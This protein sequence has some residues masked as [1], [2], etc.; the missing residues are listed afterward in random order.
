MFFLSNLS[1]YGR[2]KDKRPRKKRNMVIG[3]IGGTAIGAGI[4]YASKPSKYKL[5][6]I[7]RYNDIEKEYKKSIIETTKDINNPDF[8]KSYNQQRLANMQKELIEWQNNKNKII[9]G[10]AQHTKGSETMKKFDFMHNQKQLDKLGKLS[11]KIG[12]KRAL[13]GSGI[14]L[15]AGL[16]GTYLYNKLRSNNEN[17]R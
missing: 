2:G 9:K 10:Y 17:K 13:I 12:S 3:A 8:D 4:G 7:K 16:G 11:N 15:A 1:E 6:G 5:T 14:G